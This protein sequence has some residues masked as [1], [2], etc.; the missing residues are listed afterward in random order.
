M[1]IHWTQTHRTVFLHHNANKIRLD[2]S[3]ST[4]GR[5]TSITKLRYISPESTGSGFPYRRRNG[6]SPP[7]PPSHWWVPDMR[8]LLD[9]RTPRERYIAARYTPLV[10]LETNLSEISS[11]DCGGGGRQRRRDMEVTG[12]LREIY[13]CRTP[14]WGLNFAYIV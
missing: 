4:R 2:T 12:C 9:D 10:S 5:N 6:F 11:R 1:G 8:P 14:N 3:Y 7:F 13:V